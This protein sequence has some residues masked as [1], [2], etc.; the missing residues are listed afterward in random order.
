MHLVAMVAWFAGL[1]Y[2]VRLFVYIAETHN[3]DP[4]EQRVLLPQLRL[5]SNRLWFGICWPACVLTLVAGTALVSWHMPPPQWLWIKLGLIALLIVYHLGCHWLNSRL[6]AGPSPWSGATL[7]IYN[8][9]ATL[10]LVS[11]VFVAVLK[12]SMSLLWAAVGLLILAVV[13][14]IG[15]W[16]YGRLRS[17]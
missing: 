6:Q 9:G 14:G 3:Q 4:A 7:R 16:T 2:V 13:I 12:S 8:E 10:L 17:D 5:M 1:F 11:I 15:I